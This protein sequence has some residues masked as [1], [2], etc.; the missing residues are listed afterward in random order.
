M[1]KTR[2]K[3][4]DP[5]TSVDRPVKRARLSAEREAR[6]IDGQMLEG[7]KEISRQGNRAEDTLDEDVSDEEPKGPRE[8]AHASDMYLDTVCPFFGFLVVILIMHLPQFSSR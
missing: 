4:K 7:N 6:S 1:P 5:E 2:S 8:P 3:V